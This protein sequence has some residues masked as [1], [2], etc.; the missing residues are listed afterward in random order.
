MLI[1]EKIAALFH[2]REMNLDGNLW[3]ITCRSQD[4]WT[5]ESDVYKNIITVHFTTMGSV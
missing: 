2:L 3:T 1:A 5:F 4:P